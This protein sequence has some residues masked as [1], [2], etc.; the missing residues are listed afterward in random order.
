MNS[1]Q[2]I[3][4]GAGSGGKKVAASL[5]SIG[6]TITAYTDNNKS[7]WGFKLDG[8]PIIEP[9]KLMSK[10]PN[11]VIVVASMYH[12]EIVQQLKGYGISANNITISENLIYHQIN[13]MISYWESFLHPKFHSKK[14]V[15]IEA[16]QGLGL[17]GIEQWTRSIAEEFIQR[18]ISF[19]L[20]TPIDK[21]INKEPLTSYMLYINF[22]EASYLTSISE[23]VQI[24]SENLPCT[25]LLNRINQV[26]MA[27][28]IVK[29]Y[30]PEQIN[31]IYVMHNDF[32]RFYLH[33]K[34]AEQDIDTFLCVSSRIQK[35][36]KEQYSIVTPTVFL[37]SPVKSNQSF[38]KTLKSKDLPLRIG[39]AARIE[40]GQKRSELLI[41]LIKKL[42]DTKL[43][44]QMEI[45]GDGTYFYELSNIINNDITLKHI[46]LLGQLN[47]KQMKDFWKRQDIF[48]NLSDM[49]GCALTML[50]AMSYAV[51]PIMT[52]VS[53]TEDFIEDGKNGFLVEK[54]DIDTMV[55]KIIWISKNNSFLYIAGQKCRKKIIEQCNLISYTDELIKIL[56]L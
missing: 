54:E 26:Y 38:C 56:K 3:I 51:V 18:N 32:E 16:V 14:Q 19:Q 44:Y 29:H 50:E 15:W 21:T 46:H 55:E 11:A 41:P 48:I 45:A 40:K 5:Q 9:S 7:K 8:I 23:L 24:I 53:G 37:K 12:N 20:I 22:N 42:Q 49:E 1:E 30:F 36:L 31:I 13:L 52:K 34:L 28:H 39:Y 33:S 25:I 47:E 17:G 43:N 10:Y 35:T 6:Y 2:V 27:A 4:F